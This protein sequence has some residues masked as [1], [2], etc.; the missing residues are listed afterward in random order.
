MSAF[1]SLILT[2]LTVPP[3]DLIYYIVLVFAIASAL[4]S[5]FNHWRATE[6]P[7]ARR[8]LVGLGVLLLAQ[9]VMFLLSGLGWQ[10]I[11]DPKTIL[12]PMDRAFVLFSI[13]WITWLYA[14]PE[15][16]R[17]ADAAVALLSFFVL[18]ALGLSLLIWKPQVALLSYN[19][20]NDDWFW[21]I[22]SLL[23]ILIGIS[24]LFIRR[25]D[26]MW[27]GITLLAIGFLGHVG[28]MLFP[29]AGN[30]SGIVRLAYMSAF[31]I[32]LTLPQRYAVASGTVAAS[33][34][35]KSATSRAEANTQE[36]RRYSTDPK[37]FHAMLALAAESNPT[38]VSQA[39]TRAIAQTMLSDLCFMIYLTDSNKQM[40][41]AGG[42]DLIR[43]DNLEGGSLNKASIPMLANSLQRGRPLR[44]PASS[45]SADIK[46]LADLLGLSNPGHLLS[47]PILTAEKEP[48][49]GILLLSPYSDR[50]WT[51][52]DQAFLSNIATSLV[53]IIK[54]SQKVNKLEAQSDQSRIQVD[55]LERRIRELTA[56]LETS[57]A[58]GQQSS[59]EDT[60]SL[61]AAQEDSQ[62]IIEQLQLEIGELRIGNALA[63]VAVPMNG[64]SDLELKK[65]VQ[66][67]ARLQS[68]LA[69]ANANTDE[70]QKGQ[71]AVKSTEQAEVIASISQELR[72]PLSSIVGYTDLLLGESVGIL[73]AL[74]RKFV[75]RIKASTERIHNLTDDMI[76][77]TTLETELNDLKPESVDLNS[78]ID[79]AMTYTST[80]VREKNISIH[81]ELPKSL[82]P[83]HADREALQQI[84]IHLLQNA[85]AATPFEGR[86]RLN[87]QTQT[88][89]GM[90]YIL[91][92]VADSGG[93]IA[94]QD[95]QRAFTRLY[96]ADNVLIQ[97]IGDT[98]VG[99]SIAKTLTEAQHGRIWVESEQ[100]VGSTFSVLLPIAS[101]VESDR[102][103]KVKGKK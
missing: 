8:A 17:A 33:V 62:Q 44:M 32:L 96:R 102:K 69:E 25:P 63:A 46:G 93:G 10:N 59:S 27:G 39:I 79:N 66:E 82:A 28:H 2:Q 11:I 20:T 78:I 100:G 89:D 22:G 24:T 74:Q 47:V 49:G 15:P 42:Y 73:G 60:A 58:A 56:E 52:E 76:Q 14:F 19:Q 51:A 57:H 38:K 31:P 43:E 9:L 71:V 5:S 54:R 3:G 30:Y 1:S 61:R 86:V 68:Q 91:I 83:V 87:V 97:G 16:S 13:L 98:G 37:T 26:G 34:P 18:T 65:A 21:Q 85:G 81:L 45:T 92:Q 50:T 95:L 48:L 6:F 36:R 101:G 7:Q 99:L 40:V 84:L 53:P 35:Q 90:E 103:P 77:I 88:E 29:V 80:Q 75:E 23:A 55:D 72:Q 4:Q 94:P 70:I 41:I 67:V 12:P 64:G